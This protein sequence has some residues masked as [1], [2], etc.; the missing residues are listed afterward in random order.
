MRSSDEWGDGGAGKVV[1]ETR[2]SKEGR[3]M[4]GRKAMRLRNMAGKEGGR[5]LKLRME[6]RRRGMLWFDGL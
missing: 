3:R 1:G 5:R 4:D 2:R 6:S